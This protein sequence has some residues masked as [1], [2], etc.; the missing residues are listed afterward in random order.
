MFSIGLVS[1]MILVQE[2]LF[3]DYYQYENYAGNFKETLI[4]EVNFIKFI[5][6]KIKQKVAKM[7]SETEEQL[8]LEN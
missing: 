4:F 7:E 1:S 3:K 5:R 6:E 8:S 2:I